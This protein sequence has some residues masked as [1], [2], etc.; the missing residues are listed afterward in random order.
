[1]PVVLSYSLFSSRFRFCLTKC[2][3]TL[4]RTTVPSL[5]PVL[6][7]L[8]VFHRELKVRSTLTL[9]LVFLCVLTAGCS[10]EPSRYPVK[11]TVTI[12]GAPLALAHVNFVAV[13]P[14]TPTS[15]G[16]STTT[17]KDGNFT[18]TNGDKTPGLMA[19]E[20]KVIFQQTLIN[21]QPT[22]GG[23]RGKRNAMGPG[24]SEGVPEPYLTPDTTPMRVTIPSDT[25][26]LK[27]EIKK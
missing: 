17:D 3:R 1:M 23:A 4:A 8:D 2:S 21:G 6:S 10:R 26:S 12:N 19:G 20:Y 18:I 9:P 11:G 25:D 27:L 5:T 13:N 24:E 16:A 14:A 15:S 22:F 7:P